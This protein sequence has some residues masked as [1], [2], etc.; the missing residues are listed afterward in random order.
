MAHKGFKCLSKD[1]RLYI[2]RDVVFDEHTF[3]YSP[4]PSTQ[5]SS[6]EPFPHSTSGV[7]PLVS[8]LNVNNPP[9]P[10][11][12][13]PLNSQT[14]PVSAAH[15]P[16]FIEQS[17]PSHVSIE[18]VSVRKNEVVAPMSNIPSSLH[19]T[20]AT[21]TDV[22]VTLSPN[23]NPSLTSTNTW[24]RK[25]KALLAIYEPKFVKSAL[26]EPHWF[27]AM[28]TEMEDIYMQQPPGFID[29]DYPTYASDQ[30]LFIR[31]TSQSCIYILV[32]VNDILI[33]GS[34]NNLVEKLIHE[35]SSTFS[36]KDLGTVDYFLSIQ[37]THTSA[38]ILLTQTKYLQ[39]LL[40][41]ANMHNVNTQHT[42]MN[43][44]LKLSNYGSEP[45]EDTTL[46]M[47][48]VVALQYTTITRPELAFCVNKQATISRSS[49][50]AEFRS[51]ASTVAE[52]TWIQSLLRELH[53]PQT[54]ILSVWCD[55]QSTVP[56]AANP[57]LHAR[58]KHIEIDLY[59]VRD[60]V[61]VIEARA[62]LARLCSKAWWL[63]GCWACD[64]SGMGLGV[65]RA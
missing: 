19:N 64:L 22:P 8:F 31:V 39:D 32:Y 41:K 60:K 17:Q 6:I 51:L 42:P 10:P 18:P 38:G 30:S 2:S 5:P 36:L 53:I 29:P 34:D 11:T 1:N 65:R 35:L 48:I 45:V 13:I 40:T 33:M 16:V 26:Q 52:V 9:T 56:L 44:G 50:E 27:N 37:V 21:L 46:Y 24:I 28:S 43:S 4:K 57:V 49:S 12:V 54:V 15:D 62:D 58:T 3:P 61:D 14:V 25:P 63:T 55:N 59:F 47:S 20:T 7:P 23:V